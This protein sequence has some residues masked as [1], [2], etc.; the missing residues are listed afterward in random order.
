M[1]DMVEKDDDERKD[2]C[3]EGE[4]ND[5]QPVT[6]KSVELTIAR[7]MKSNNKVDT[8]ECTGDMVEILED[9]EA[10]GV[11][12]IIPLEIN[13]SPEKG[14]IVVANREGDWRGVGDS[15]RSKHDCNETD[16]A[17]KARSHSDNAQKARRQSGTLQIQNF[18][19]L[20]VGAKELLN[21][22]EQQ[23]PA[24]KIRN[25]KG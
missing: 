18:Q 15:M 11:M 8:V 25:K 4:E 21:K 13:E 7:G 24:L 2:T 1:G 19:E 9:W 12:S 14:E 20:L 16:E 3:K 17:Q 6:T 22:D 10:S 5:S 23:I